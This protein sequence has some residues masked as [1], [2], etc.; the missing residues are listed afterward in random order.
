[1]LAAAGIVS[2]VALLDAASD[3]TPAR[4]PERDEVELILSGLGLLGGGTAALLLRR[5]M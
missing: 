2:S 3:D 4:T 1:M 5:R